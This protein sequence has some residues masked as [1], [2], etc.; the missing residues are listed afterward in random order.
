VFGKRKETEM[1]RVMLLVLCLVAMVGVFGCSGGNTADDKQQRDQ[2][3]IVSEGARQVGMPRI[4]NF[5]AMKLMREIIE[6]Q[7][8]TSIV[9]Y[10]YLKNDMSGRLVF[11]G[12]AMGYGIPYASQFTNPQ[13][14]I[15]WD[16][17]ITLPQ[18]DPDGLFKPSSNA[19]TLVMMINPETN[20]PMPV[21]FESD[22]TVSPFP[23]PCENLSELKKGQ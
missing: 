15:S 17:G 10:V 21:C 2:E 14:L 9:T 4:V 16:R 5:R 11:V 6:L 1:K 12:R 20:K 7:D 3:A 22:I 18:A 19:G 13:K 23:L 8:N